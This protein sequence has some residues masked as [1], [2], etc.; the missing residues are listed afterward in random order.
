MIQLGLGCKGHIIISTYSRTCPCQLQYISNTELLIHSAQSGV[1]L[2]QLVLVVS[3]VIKL[4]KDVVCM[5]YVVSLFLS[6][7]VCV[8]VCVC[9]CSSLG[10]GVSIVLCIDSRHYICAFDGGIQMI[11]GAWYLLILVLNSEQTDWPYALSLLCPLKQIL[12]NR[13]IELYQQ[14]L[15]RH[16]LGFHMLYKMATG[17]S[18]LHITSDDCI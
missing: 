17:C 1:D 13:T 4:C 8:C 2:L 9:V 5:R 11:V 14:V 10:W 15:C 12:I 18:S 16:S 3:S 6:L 7:C